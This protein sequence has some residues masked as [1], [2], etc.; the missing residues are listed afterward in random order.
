MSIH[1][2]IASTGLNPDELA[3][4]VHEWRQRSFQMETVL[5]DHFDVE[6]LAATIEVLA[7]ELDRIKTLASHGGGPLAR[8]ILAE[9]EVPITPATP[10]APG[11]WTRSLVFGYPAFRHLS[12]SW[13]D[14]DARKLVRQ[15][16]I[17]H[18]AT[19]AWAALAD[20]ESVTGACDRLVREL[21]SVTS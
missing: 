17:V 11:S 14:V 15:D 9:T 7:A 5:A 12:Y 16:I 4:T 2:I 10:P 3:A 13:V 21:D 18:A 1:Q 8:A 20:G 19:G 6:Q